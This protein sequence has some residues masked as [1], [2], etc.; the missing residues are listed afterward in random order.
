MSRNF[1]LLHEAGKAQEMLRQRMEQPVASAPAEFV[2]GTPAL[3]MEEA[4]REEVTKLVHRLFLMSG[5]SG[6]RQVVF[7]GTEQGNGCSWICAHTA[8]I[9][10]SRVAG[11]VCVVDCHL[12]LPT[13]HEQ[14]HVRNH[15]G[16]SD[17]LS[18]GESI[19]QFVQQL[20]RPNLWLLSCGSRSEAA[21]P[22]LT[23]EKMRKRMF[24][25]RAEFDYVLLDVGPLDSSNDGALLGSWCDGVTLVLKANSSN[26][27]AA[28][29]ALQD[30]QNANAPV[31]G[32]V[33]NQRT[34]P[35][36]DSIYSRL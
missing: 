1:E 30:V 22:L 4:A 13:L 19:R 2:P 9:L 15:Y 6:A 21:Q 18:G 27:K 26:R 35:I 17:A 28:Q 20:S 14:F 5:A 31:L 10:A 24:E 23:S 29:K 11:S 33:L 32:A 7:T 16:L 12:K 36:P 34:F 8:D 3:Q 25:L